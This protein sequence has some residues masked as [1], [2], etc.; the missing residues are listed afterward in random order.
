MFCVFGGG[1][2]GG[3]P[4]WR[5]CQPL[6]GRCRADIDEGELEALGDDDADDN[7]LSDMADV[8]A[9]AAQL[10]VRAPHAPPAR[11]D[12]AL[13][14]A[15]QLVASPSHSAARMVPGG[16]QGLAKS[17]RRLLKQLQLLERS[18]PPTCCASL[19]MDAGIA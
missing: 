11:P 5:L 10:P 3:F 7:G 6:T 14:T 9:A 12:A 1:G 16:W 17:T 2:A 15:A 13:T 4:R 19:H 8:K 18:A